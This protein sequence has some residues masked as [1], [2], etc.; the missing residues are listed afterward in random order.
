M[1]GPS[2]TFP[3][4]S[5]A[6]LDWFYRAS[7]ELAASI[8]N[9]KGSPRAIANSF[10]CRPHRSSVASDGEKSHG[11]GM[12]FIDEALQYN[13]G[14]FNNNTKDNDDGV[15]FSVMGQK[16]TGKTSILTSLAASYLVK[17]SRE[18]YQSTGQFADMTPPLVIV[19]DADYGIN[20]DQISKYAQ[21]AVM[22]TDDSYLYKDE[23][24]MAAL[25]SSILSRLH[26]TRVDDTSDFFTVFELVRHALDQDAKE[27]EAAWNS[28]A[29]ST[30]S[31]QS[32]L[33]KFPAK[34]RA[35]PMLIIDTLNAFELCDRMLP[36]ETRQSGYNDYMRQLQRLVKAHP[37]LIIFACRMIFANSD[38]NNRY[39]SFSSISTSDPWNRMM[40][41]RITLER[42]T[43][44]IRAGNYGD[45]SKFDFVARL[46]HP[47]SPQYQKGLV[48]PFTISP[49]G[50][51]S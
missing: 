16:G 38:Y 4:R 32:K 20:I 35:P 2:T 23:A 26:I 49:A 8:A 1:E 9:V 29:G 22:R 28:A 47:S 37:P 5:E 27:A 33:K 17:T 41:H 50:V 43:D 34:A 12:S 13:A 31:H 15:V 24:H 45:S 6:A 39:S 48:I 18:T 3:C 30:Q 40:T 44:Q 46:G 10:L 36:D 51:F 25:V 7:E 14:M 19:L 11:T 21:T 42:T